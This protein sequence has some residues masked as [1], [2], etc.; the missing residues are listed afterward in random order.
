VEVVSHSALLPGMKEEIITV[1]K[2]VTAAMAQDKNALLSG[3]DWVEILK[4]AASEA[5][6]NPAR[7]FGA[8]Y[9]N[10]NLALAADTLGL[11]LRTLPPIPVSGGGTTGLILKGDIIRDA[12]TIVLRYV[13]GAPDRAQKYRPL[14]ET[15]TKEISNFVADNPGSFGSNEWLGLIRVVTGN[16]LDGTYDVQ[17]AQLVENPGAGVRLIAGV[18]AADA[19]LK[20]GA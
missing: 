8:N 20:G 15:A 2:A 5:S 6:A 17:L 9:N 3:A 4:A 13:S 1:A 14:L 18:Q 12:M 11:V 16:I 10:Q 19:L 7:L